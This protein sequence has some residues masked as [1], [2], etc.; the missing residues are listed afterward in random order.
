MTKSP[1]QNDPTP[2]APMRSGTHPHG[3]IQTAALLALLALTS[4]SGC[5]TSF[6]KRTVYDYKPSY[7]VASPDFQHHLEVQASGLPGGN[8]A[9]LLNNGDGF[10]PAILEA[11][12]GARASVNI[13]LYIFAK[14]MMAEQFVEALC[15]KAREGIEVRVLV[16][17]VGERLGKLGD[18]LKECGVNFQIYKPRK[19]FS[20]A[21]TGD[22]THRKI[23]TVDGRIGF[24]GGLAIDD[25]WAGDARNPDE[26]R[27]TVVRVEGPAVLLLQRVFLEDWLYTTGEVLDGPRQFPVAQ[28]VGDVKAQAVAS[29]R[30]S[31][32]SGAKLHYYIPMQAARDHIWI[33]NAYFLPDKDIRVALCAAAR[34]G[35]DV[36]VVVPGEHID[37]KAVRYAARGYYEEL[38]KAGVKIYEY[39]PTMIHCKVM[40]VDGVWSSIGSMNFTARSMK[41]NAEANVAIYDEVFACEVRTVIEAD[42][43]RSEQILLER[44]K[45][46]G[47]GERTKEWFYGLYKNLF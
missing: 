20:I 21:K 15:A 22:R 18:K 45:K 19:L 39:Q 10:F 8:Q 2:G 3:R 34:R 40:V 9:T 1:S 5:A 28:E 6:G 7:G 13:E 43:A 32:L 26:W 35:V 46:R 14:G 16:D 42:I 33:E 41:A 37:I 12:H 30:T 24:T 23:I 29:S 11:I 38:L 27:D 25:R 17:A 31:Q 44:W 47:S 4:L 36:R